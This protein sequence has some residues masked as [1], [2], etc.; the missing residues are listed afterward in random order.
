MVRV[1][2]A[3]R[4]ES[5]SSLWVADVDRLPRA[6]VRAAANHL[7][8]E[9]HA[10]DFRAEPD[11]ARRSINAWASDH[12]RGDRRGPFPESA[13]TVQVESALVT[14][15]SFSCG[16]PS[17]VGWESFKPPLFDFIQVKALFSES[18]RVI[19]RPSVQAAV[20]DYPGTSLSL[21]VVKPSSWKAFA[22][23]EA[24]FARLWAALSRAKEAVLAIPTFKLSSVRDLVPLLMH[25]GI[26][27]S[28][29]SRL[30]PQ[31]VPDAELRTPSLDR[32]AHQ[33]L[34]QVAGIPMAPSQ[35]EEEMIRRRR[36]QEKIPFPPMQWW[37]WVDERSVMP[38]LRVDA[39]FYFLLVHK[40]TGLILLMGQVIDPEVG[41]RN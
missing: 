26:P 22:W 18:C 40:Q 3:G 12:C 16:W 23:N 10:I 17:N 31:A 15:A 4:F 19:F 7:P 13:I 11:R 36:Y 28:S 30:L 37:P 38:W 27:I 29:R 20:V 21:V 32:I 2:G 34:I 39:A 6:Y 8:G 35:R 25:M 24:A 1:E 41:I 9:L 33:A 14:T 5:A